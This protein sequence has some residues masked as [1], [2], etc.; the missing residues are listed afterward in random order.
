MRAKV[1][2]TD[3]R[4]DRGRGFRADRWSPDILAE[5]EFTAKVSHVGVTVFS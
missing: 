5:R 4:N 3:R 1:Q 2:R